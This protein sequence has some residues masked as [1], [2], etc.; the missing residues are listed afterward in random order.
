LCPTNPPPEPPTRTPSNLHIYRKIVS[1]NQNC[2]KYENRETTKIDFK[3][4]RS[5]V[6]LNLKKG[7]P[8]W[9]CTTSHYAERQNSQDSKSSYRSTK[10]LSMR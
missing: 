3:I 6:K 10:F 7:L 8:L 2:N 4:G 9:V 5:K 1:W